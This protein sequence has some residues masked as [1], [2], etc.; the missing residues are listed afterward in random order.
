MERFDRRLPFV[1][2]LSAVLEVEQ[3]RFISSTRNYMKVSDPELL[4]RFVLHSSV[5]VRNMYLL[6]RSFSRN[7]PKSSSTDLVHD[8]ILRKKL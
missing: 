1:V 3:H 8:C 2:F 6:L 7:A 5:N 4:G